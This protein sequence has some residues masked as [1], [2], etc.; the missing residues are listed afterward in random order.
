M[1]M[2]IYIYIYI[3]LHWTDVET[4]F[5]LEGLSPIIYII[6]EINTY[7]QYM[8]QIEFLAFKEGWMRFST[9]WRLPKKNSSVE[10]HSLKLSHIKKMN[11]HITT[12]MHMLNHS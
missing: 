8:K 6:T 7:M 4:D 2:Y 11:E 9:T 12:T 5:G 1:Y 3:Y 10:E